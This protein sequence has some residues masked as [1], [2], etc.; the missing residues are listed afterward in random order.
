MLPLTCCKTGV[1]GAGVQAQIASTLDGK[2]RR[3][4]FKDLGK[5]P[6][7]PVNDRDKGWLET[8]IAVQTLSSFTSVERQ[9]T[10]HPAIYKLFYHIS[11]G[12]L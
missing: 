5:G 4:L 12:S 3:S 11:Q 9:K 1:G 2:R 8:S 10:K 6:R 7:E